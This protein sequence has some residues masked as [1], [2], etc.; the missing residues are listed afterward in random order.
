MDLA[1]PSGEAARLPKGCH[2][3]RK[4]RQWLVAALA[5]ACVV[6]ISGAATE[7]RAQ[8][9]RTNATVKAVQKVKPSVVAVKV[10]TPSGSG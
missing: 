8:E 5:A 2:C 4:H 9:S 7:T 10:P 3:M 6:A 1:S